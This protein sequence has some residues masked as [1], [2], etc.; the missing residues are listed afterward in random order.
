MLKNAM[1]NAADS[2]EAGKQQIWITE[3]ELQRQMTEKAN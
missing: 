1:A 2:L 3:A